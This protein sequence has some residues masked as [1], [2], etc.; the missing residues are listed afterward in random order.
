M[1]IYYLPLELIDMRYTKDQDDVTQKIFNKLN[2]DYKTINGEIL[3]DKKNPDEFLN[4]T[5]TNFFKFRQLEQICKC[6]DNGEVKDGDIFYVS[7]IWFPG[8]ESIKYM[9]HF[10]NINVKLYGVLHAGSFTPSDTVEGL[11][12]W[13][14]PFEESLIKMFDGIFLGSEQTRQDLLKAFN[15]GFTDLNKLH[16]TGLSY[17]SK[18]VEKYRIPYNKKEDIIVFPHRLHPEKQEYLFDN[19]KKFFPCVKFVTTHRENLTKEEYYKLLAKSKIVYSASL[20]ENFG[21]S[22]LEAC[23]LGVTPILPNNNT[24]YKYMYPKEILYDTFEESVKLVEKYLKQSLDLLVLPHQY[25]D[26]VKRQIKIIIKD[27]E[28]KK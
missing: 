16:V 26:S 15:L 1:K 5:S 12:E 10:K 8:I 28:V 17:D 20:Q 21:Y 22:V 18:N 13:A 25:N 11:K 14:R 3:S 27:N 24:C 4:P 9:A 7:D 6:F 23:S 2:I 19:L